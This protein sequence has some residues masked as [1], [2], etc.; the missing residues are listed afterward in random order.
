MCIKPTNKFPL[1]SILMWLMIAMAEI[2]LQRKLH[3]I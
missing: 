3:K 2:C 1:Q